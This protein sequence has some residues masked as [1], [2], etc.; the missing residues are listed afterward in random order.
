MKII[1]GSQKELRTATMKRSQL[2]YKANKT[3][4][5]GDFGKYIQ[6]CNHVV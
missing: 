3:K 2:K 1:R 4:N 5:P 6:Q